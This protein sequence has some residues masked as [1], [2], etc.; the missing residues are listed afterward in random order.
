MSDKAYK[1][2]TNREIR[3][4]ARERLLGNMLIPCLVTFFFFSARNAFEMFMQLGILGTDMFAFIF[5]IALFIT[6]NSIWGL[7]RFGISRYFLSFITTKKASPANIF[8]GFKG[9]TETIIGVSLI[10]AI[11]SLVFQLPYLIY[12]FFFSV[13]TIHSFLLSLVLFIAGNLIVYLIEAYLAPIYFVICD[14]PGSRL[15]WIF[16]IT[17]SLMNTKNFFKYIALQISFIPMYFLGL[18][19]CFIGLLWV[20]P[21]AYTS[22]AY[23]YESLCE[24]YLSRQAKKEEV[25]NK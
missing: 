18:L 24:E 23:F 22:Y 7:I 4:Y 10:L 8:A 16:V 5:Y 20:V 11:I 3:S 25:S 15:P 13:N 19:S 9:S 2:R 14:N 6:I 1:V 12:T 21:Y 17:F